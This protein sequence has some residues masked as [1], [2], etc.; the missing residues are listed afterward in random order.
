MAKDN[1][2]LD[3]SSIFKRFRRSQQQSTSFPITDQHRRDRD[4]VI[5]QT[6]NNDK[7]K[8]IHK[9]VIDYTYD[10]TNNNL[11]LTTDWSS[12]NITTVM[13]SY[14]YLNSRTNSIE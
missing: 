9:S 5:N 4:S 6:L 13:S 10:N 8:S 12:M 1:A 11:Q 14:F 3:Q 2:Q 7:R